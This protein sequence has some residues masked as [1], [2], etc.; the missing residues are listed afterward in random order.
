M[1]VRKGTNR[2]SVESERLVPVTIRFTATAYEAIRQI[3]HEHSMSMATTVRMATD[4]NFK[5]YLSN[6]KFLDYD[7]GKKVI[8]EVTSLFNECSNIGFQLRRIGVNFNQ[9]ARARNIENQYAEQIKNASVADGLA[10]IKQ[11]DKELEAIKAECEPLDMDKLEELIS[12]YEAA[13]ERVNNL[14]CP[15]LR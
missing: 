6:L 14:L 12:R 9:I 11:R 2:R 3:A 7:Q 10:L 4:M 5:R 15:I 1:S 13:T 8:E